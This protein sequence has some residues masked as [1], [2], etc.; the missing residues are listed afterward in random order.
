MNSAR[1]SVRTESRKSQLRDEYKASVGVD[2]SS[3]VI[4]GSAA[5]YDS[6]VSLDPIDVDD[7]WAHDWEPL[8]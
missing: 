7:D 2:W 1:D 3:V 6:F 4:A 8:P 5:R